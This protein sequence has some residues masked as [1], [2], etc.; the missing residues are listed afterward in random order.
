MKPT[1]CW[2]ISM[3]TL[4]LNFSVSTASSYNMPPVKNIRGS[5]YSITPTNST[6]SHSPDYS[7]T[8]PENYYTDKLGLSFEFVRKKTALESIFRITEVDN[9]FDDGRNMLDILKSEWG[10]SLY[11]RKLTQEQNAELV[12]H[13]EALGMRHNTVLSDSHLPSNPDQQL[14]IIIPSHPQLMWHQMKEIRHWIGPTV[15]PCNIAW[16]V[17]SPKKMYSLNSIRET[18]AGADFYDLAV[19]ESLSQHGFALVSQ[20]S[21]MTIF[22]DVLFPDTYRH[23]IEMESDDGYNNTALLNYLKLQRNHLSRF[24]SVL[25]ACIQPLCQGAEKTVRHLLGSAPVNLVKLYTLPNQR[26]LERDG[27]NKH[28][29]VEYLTALRHYIEME[30]TLNPK[31]Q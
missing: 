24:T 14:I 8:Q 9:N 20:D 25:L 11:H 4:L 21:L 2:S 16:L 10:P 5:A 30:V 28:W 1:S 6:D 13:F 15:P 27:S 29:F 31:Q 3:L 17:A 18:L 12:K 23:V 19:H 7:I 22:F 26:K